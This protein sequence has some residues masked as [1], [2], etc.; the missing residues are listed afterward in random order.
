[1]PR[2]QSNEVNHQDLS[3]DNPANNIVLLHLAIASINKSL[4]DCLSSH[5]KEEP[6]DRVKI[7]KAYRGLGSHHN[8]NSLASLGLIASGFSSLAAKALT[9]DDSLAKAIN[10]LSNAGVST[11]KDY[12]NGQIQAFDANA[13]DVAKKEAEKRQEDVRRLQNLEDRARESTNA[14]INRA[15]EAYQIRG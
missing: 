8:Y 15:I 4:Q 11:F 1:M 12:N 13:I 5:L 6:E 14:A 2:I 3:L 7:R 10:E 9:G